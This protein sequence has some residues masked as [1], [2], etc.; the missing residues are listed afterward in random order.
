[1]KRYSY[2]VNFKLGK[3]SQ[4]IPMMTFLILLTI[5]P[6]GQGKNLY[7]VHPYYLNLE[8]DGRANGVLLMNSNAMGK[9][10]LGYFNTLCQ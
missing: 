10:Q 7:G 4:V 8:A 3:E 9:A 1:M 6:Q 2:I 5:L